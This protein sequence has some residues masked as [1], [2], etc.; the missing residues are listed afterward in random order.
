MDPLSESVATSDLCPGTVNGFLWYCDEHDTHGNAD[1]LEEAEA[2]G[3]AHGNLM[4]QPDELC[5]IT[6]LR[7]DG[8]QTTFLH[9]RR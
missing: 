8:G 3:D 7:R 2:L 9:L 4:G 5:E 6:L 1:S